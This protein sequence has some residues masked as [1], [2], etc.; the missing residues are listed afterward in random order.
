MSTDQKFS[1]R[2]VASKPA[3]SKK[4]SEVTNSKK[5][6]LFVGALPP[7]YSERELL[8][9]F[10]QFGKIRKLRLSRSK[11]TARSRGYAYIQ[12]ELP[13]V[14]QIAASSTNSY[15][16][17][18]KPIRVELLNPE[19]VHSGLW[20]GASATDPIIRLTAKA[21]RHHARRSH[22]TMASTALERDAKRQEKL[23]AAGIEYSLER[24]IVEKTS[25]KVETA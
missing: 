12:Y 20:K 5:S 17:G 8:A 4:Q 9:F 2:K 15:I 18:G 6:V 22:T 7:V 19:A 25:K 14:A 21:R 3:G 23:A 1:S 16:I 10:G 24:R 13:E 11:K